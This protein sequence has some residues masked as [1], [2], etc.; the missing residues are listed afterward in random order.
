M[1]LAIFD[2]DETL[3]CGDTASLFCRRLVKLGLATPDF[4]AEEARLMEAYAARTLDMADYVRFLMHPLSQ[5][6][7]AQVAALLPAFIAEDI[8][9]RI[10]PQAHQLLHTLAE[11]NTRILIISATPTF[12]VRAV[13]E[14]L[15]VADVLAI[16]LAVTDNHY[17]GEIEGIASYQAGKI[18]R[19][20]AWL[21]DHPFPRADMTFYS[22]SPNDLP[23]LEYVP[24][25]VATNP[26]PMLEAIA[27]EN[28]WDIL[29]WQAPSACLATQP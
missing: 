11:Q 10:Y 27:N 5:L 13:A 20:E 21:R 17:N 18:T 7:T 9:P 28:Q 29:H 12:L 3:L 16:D 1:P 22:D 24:H 8:A 4:L 23:L 26:S 2:L 25:P 6:S 14:H 15:G 19:L